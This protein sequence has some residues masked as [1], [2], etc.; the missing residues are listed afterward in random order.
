M[1][2]VFFPEIITHDK[3]EYVRVKVW[4]WKTVVFG[5]GPTAVAA[6]NLT[7][8][9]CPLSRSSNRIVRLVSAES[10]V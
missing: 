3:S 10:L 4:L 1:A 9:D 5:P 2:K 7:S 8:Y 6:C